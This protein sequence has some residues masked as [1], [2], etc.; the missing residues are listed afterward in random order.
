MNNYKE[1]LDMVEASQKD[2]VYSALLT[3]EEAVLD[4]VN[5]MIEKKRD[6]KNTG[7]LDLSIYELI[8]N[9]ALVWK[10]IY[11]EAVIYKQRD[12]KAL[13][14]DNERKIYMGIMFVMIALFLYFIDISRW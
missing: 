11:L 4:T 5:R 2:D 6:D 13:F 8:T 7:F 12:V 14:Y 10:R 3:K 9:F 1:I